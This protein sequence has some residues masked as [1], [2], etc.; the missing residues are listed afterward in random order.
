MFLKTNYLKYAIFALFLAIKPVFSQKVG[1]VL[2]GGGSS[3]MAHIGVLKAL[4]ENN[5]P[6]DYITGTSIGS[7][8][9]AYY[10]IGYSP[11]QI[12]KMV[13]TSFF[14]NASKGDLNYQYGY[15]FKKRNTYGSWLTFRIDPNDEVLK[16]LPTNVINSIPID[17][18]LMETFAAASARAKYNFDSLLVPYRCVASDIQSK[19]SIVFKSGD[20]STSLRASMSY[21]FYLRPIK[22]DGKLLFDGGLYNNFPSDVMYKDFNPDFIIG[23]N[24]ADKNASP[25]DDDLYLQ[26]RNIMMSETDFKPVCENGILIEPWSDVSMFNFDRVDRLIDSGYAATIRNLP[27]IRAQIKRRTDTLLLNEK[28][29][30][31]LKDYDKNKIVFD[32]VNVNGLNEKQTRYVTQNLFYKKQEFSLNDLKRR[33]FRL[34]ADER[35]KS[36]YPVVKYDSTTKKYALNIEAKKE[37]PFFVDAGAIISNRPISEAFLGIQYNHIGRV[38][39]SAYAN[40]YLG[41]LNSGGHLKLRFDFP[42]RVPFFV[43]SNSTYSRWDY[44][45]SSIL[46]YDLLK[47]AYLIQEDQYSELKVG[48]P[49]GNLSLLDVSGGI[50]EWG[51]FYYQRDDFTKL[52]TTDKTYFDYYYGQMNYSINT[53]NRKMYATE[54]VFFNARARYLQGNESF[55]PGNT[56]TD[57]VGFRN[58]YTQPWFQFKVT[59]D[60]YLKTLKRFRVGLFGEFVS[61]SQTFFSNYQSSILSAPAF[62]PTPESQ[63]FF[64][65]DYR[66]HNY[67]AAG[68]KLVTTPLKNLDIRFE[69]YV[70]QPFNSILKD[71]S[72]NAKLSSP[73]LYRHFIGMATMVYNTPLGPIS[74]GVNY[75]DKYQNPFS[76]FFHFG[77]IIFNKKSID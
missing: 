33:Y 1:L 75:Y 19:Q 65:D 34:A 58:K 21:P 59:F 32:K 45:N 5:I 67:L 70:M 43:E 2:S 76:L 12:E 3:G 61:S 38:G 50:A 14:Q 9:G 41:K 66:A 18:F 4:E 35:L 52:D 74:L 62:N 44:F 11:E 72:N 7:L 17:Y 49:V 26:L 15:Y 8:I 68:A 57:T 39:F 48:L 24:V 6:I 10:A 56:S 31:L 55:Y 73:F 27:A 46:F 42:G 64:I 30:N 22:V 20:L 23:S 40:G 77:Y 25:E 54:G 13:K 29:R 37:K 16:N 69:G 36:I 51:N 60:G 63:T 28:R 47:P 53:L 71:Q